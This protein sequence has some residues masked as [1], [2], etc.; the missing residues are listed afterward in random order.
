MSAMSQLKTKVGFQHDTPR[1]ATC[2]HQ[3]QQSRWN[4]GGAIYWYRHCDL[5]GFTISKNACCD[6]WQGKTGEVLG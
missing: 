5:H 1:C 6:T 2:V 4:P 3:K